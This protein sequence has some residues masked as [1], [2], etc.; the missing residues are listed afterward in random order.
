MEP[1]AL[2]RAV[3]RRNGLTQADLA[4]AAGTSQPVISAYERGHRDPTH[5]T[6]RRL[7]AAAGEQLRLDA[8]PSR[9]DLPPPAD[10]REHADRLVSVLSLV[11]AVPRARLRSRVLVA[12]RLVSR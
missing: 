12:P 4:Q 5:G 8:G 10:L 1:G 3:R 6:L 2:L 7:V 11:D 9:S